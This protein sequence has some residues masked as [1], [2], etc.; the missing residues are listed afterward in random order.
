MESTVFGGIKNVSNNIADMCGEDISNNTIIFDDPEFLTNSSNDVIR[1]IPASSLRHRYRLKSE[2]SFLSQSFHGSRRNLQK[3]VK[4]AL[5][6][7]TELG[8]PT[9]FL[10]VT[11]NPKQSEITSRLLEGQSAFDRPDI[12]TVPIFHAKLKALINNL[13][14]QKYFREELVYEMR[15]IEYQHRGMPHAHIV[16]KLKDVPPNPDGFIDSDWIDTNLSAEMPIIQ[17]NNLNSEKEIE[18]ARKVTKHMKHHCCSAVN[19]CLDKDGRCKK[20]F[21][22]T[23]ITHPSYTKVNGEW[24]IRDITYVTCL[25]CHIIV[26]YCRT[27]M[28]THTVIYLY[29]YLYKGSKKDKLKLTNADDV[30]DDDEINLY[31]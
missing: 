25:Q 5:A 20:G 23:V 12:I 22:D 1:D 21:H 18:Y 4:N 30:R 3:L 7:V 26:K 16:L 29:K 14:Y 8:K 24:Y 10:T 27:G 11:C 2:P 15:S 6:I 19:G 28:D 9:L 13:K 31:F 17:D